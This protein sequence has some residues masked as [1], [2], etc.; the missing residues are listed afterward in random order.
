M[1][2]MTVTFD[3]LPAATEVHDDLP[4]LTFDLGDAFEVATSLRAALR[5]VDRLAEAWTA[6]DAMA[7]RKADS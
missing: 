3:G 6:T 1:V 5:E 2:R 4:G 7:P